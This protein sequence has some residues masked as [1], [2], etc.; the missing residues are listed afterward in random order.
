MVASHFEVI[1][2]MKRMRGVDLEEDRVLEEPTPTESGNDTKMLPSL[3]IQLRFLFLLNGGTEGLPTLP[4]LSLI[5]D[6]IQIPVAYLPIYYAVAFL[7][8]SFKPLYAVI[9]TSIFRRRHWLLV[10]NLI[11]SSIM[12]IFTALLGENQVTLCILVAFLR[13]MFTSFA[14]FLVG[15]TLIATAKLNGN[16]DDSG[17]ALPDE[18]SEE[19]QQILLSSYQ[20]QAATSRNIGSFL[21]Q[22]VTFSIILMK[23]L[24]QNDDD[25]DTALQDSWVSFFLLLTAS[26][27]MI[28]AASALYFQVGRRFDSRY[29]NYQNINIESPEG[30]L[31]DGRTIQSLWSTFRWEIISLLLFQS[32]MVLLA[33][34]SLIIESSNRETWFISVLLL[35]GLFVYV[36]KKTLQNRSYIELNPEIGRDERRFNHLYQLGLYLI[37]RHSVPSSSSVQ[38]SFTYSFFRLYPLYFQSVGVMRSTVAILSSWSYGKCIALRFASL[39][40]LKKVIT[41]TTLILSFMALLYI[42]FI[43]Y[44]RAH[45]ENIG[46]SVLALYTLCQLLE[47]Y[48]GQISFLPSV[49]LAS[50][51][52]V[53]Q[54]MAHSTLD[55]E[56]NK[57]DTDNDSVKNTHINTGPPGIRS[58]LLQNDAILYGVLIACIDFGGQIGDL[59]SVPIIQALDIQRDEKWQNLEWFIIICSTLSLASLLAL[60]LVSTSVDK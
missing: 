49:I 60:S 33:L 47:S 20:S 46:W 27:P 58:Q 39:S 23:I 1:L 11:G 38:S 43:K 56:D 31:E 29:D 21:A 55:K 13:G 59:I 22:I 25:S 8:Y 41:R 42:P 10:F 5:N 52:A 54:G 24:R 2:V 28:G 48:V 7:P 34:R 15:I 26:L 37:L 44:F 3:P 14:E 40:G 4:L 17:R 51:S 19:K 53:Q 16:T 32:I 30:P 18:F 12:F 36:L 6:R 50:N 9:S 35:L 57:F 45:Y